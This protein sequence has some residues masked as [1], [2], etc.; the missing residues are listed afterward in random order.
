MQEFRKKGAG[1]VSSPTKQEIC[2]KKNQQRAEKEKE[3]RL[4]IS[5]AR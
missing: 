3:Q 5:E 1:P 4:Q 2:E